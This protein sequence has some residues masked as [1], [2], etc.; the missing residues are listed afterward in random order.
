MSFPVSNSGYP[1]GSGQAV[2]P[3]M[4]ID[5]SLMGGVPGAFPGQDPLAMGVPGMFPDPLMAMNADPFASMGMSGG[6]PMTIDPMTGMPVG[7]GFGNIMPTGFGTQPS[8]LSTSGID[9]F[10]GMPI[11]GSMIDPMTGMPMVPP[12]IDPMSSMSMVPPMVDPM[13]GTA[14][15]SPFGGMGM[16]CDPM[17]S[18]FGMPGMF[19]SS[20][21]TT[22]Q[23][24]SNP[25]KDMFS[26]LMKMMMIQKLF[27]KNNEPT[28]EETSTEEGGE[29][30][31][32]GG[33]VTDNIT[34]L[35]I[36]GDPANFKAIGGS[37]G[38]I[39]LL[40]LSR[41]A[42]TSKNED[43]KAAAEFIKNDPALFKE[44]EKITN[45]G[46]GVF[47]ADDL[48][49]AMTKDSILQGTT[50]TL[51]GGEGNDTLSGGEGNE[52]IKITDNI[53]ALDQLAES[54]DD[55]EEAG[56]GKG[57]HIDG[58]LT[59]TELSRA[60]SSSDDPNIKNL[61]KYLRSSGLFTQLDDLDSEEGVSLED[62]NTA[63]ED[64]D[65]SQGTG[66]PND[67]HSSADKIDTSGVTE[68]QALKTINDKFGS[69]DALED[70]KTK[71]RKGKSDNLLSQEDLDAVINSRDKDVTEDMKKAAKF[72]KDSATIGKIDKSGT[73]N[74]DTAN[75]NEASDGFI[76]KDELNSWAT[77]YQTKQTKSDGP[78]DMQ[79][80]MQIINDNIDLFASGDDKLVSYNDFMKALNSSDQKYKPE[81]KGAL[82]YIKDHRDQFETLDKADATDDDN[83][84]VDVI[85]DASLGDVTDYGFN[86]DSKS[87][88]KN[89]EALDIVKG[90]FKDKL[91]SQ[92][93]SKSDDDK[94]SEDD[95]KSAIADSTGKY[96]AKEKA[97]MKY[98]FEVDQ[99]GGHTL[100]EGMDG[101]DDTA[102]WDD[103]SY[104]VT[105]NLDPN[106]IDND[107]LDT[108][109]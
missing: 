10:T 96:T 14:M 2:N 82:Q 58:H 55:L 54:F 80:A 88:S 25:I 68:E 99:N 38:N 79:K 70:P 34:A 71:D 22:Q 50:D 29:E 94:V 109:G 12:M 87:A 72:L 48:N 19:G 26:N 108:E 46:D 35:D 61:A 95:L 41:A 5:P 104:A 98:V 86:A 43:V 62:I 60:A 85:G 9:P 76:S 8:L 101:D 27:N 37:D 84:Q 83:V 39:S 74:P 64:P 23:E 89:K 90:I 106:A 13:A 15:S 51:A 67:P 103:I 75:V 52:E 92:K 81:V 3:F 53:T 7:G 1:W 65:I 16:Q 21:P 44:I 57:G 66:D 11:G 102:S 105:A 97:A 59:I 77:D 20:M 36:I 24:A 73:D 40:D 47:T 6:M 4:G 18:G 33:E 93:D 42:R 91:D 30:G 63:Y 78:K 32:T 17:T 31:E 45:P 69:I 100:W 49:K 56:S 107:N 28:E